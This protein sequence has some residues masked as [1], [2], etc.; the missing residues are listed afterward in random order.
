MRVHAKLCEKIGALPL[1]S[2]MALSAALAINVHASAQKIITFDAP[3][4]G[5]GWGQGT[6]PV[7]INLQ[8]VVTGNVTD[9]GNGTHGFVRDARGNITNFDAPGADP[10]AGCTCPAAINDFGVVTG[11]YR[12]SNDL[13]HG[14][15]RMPDGKIITFDDP[16]AGTANWQGTTPTAINDLDAVVGWY[17]DSNWATHGFLRAADGKI[18]TIDDTAG[19]VS[20]T[21]ASINDFGTVAG[22]VNDANNVSHGFFRTFDGKFTTFDVPASVGSSI[23]TYSA[24]INDFGVISGFYN[25]AA[26]SIYVGYIRSQGGK[27]TSFSPPQAGPWAYTGTFNVTRATLLGTATTGCIDDQ[28]YIFYPFLWDASDSANTFAIPG[29]MENVGWNYGACGDGINEGREIVGYWR[30]PSGALHGFLRLPQQDS[31]P[32]AR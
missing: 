23:G 21:P 18:T 24:A 17:F 29:Q 9:N 30:D 31:Y 32:E 19:G 6:Y 7:G 5:T 11:V 8:G 12:D 28:N 20:T 22:T 15:L 3:N 4:A 2:A 27:F 10:V 14:F 25:D 16:Q 13:N 1:L 26:T